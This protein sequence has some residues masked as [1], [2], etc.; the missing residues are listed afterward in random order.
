MMKKILTLAALTFSL[1][2]LAQGQ[3]SQLDMSKY[4][5]DLKTKS[6]MHI[7]SERA[8]SMSYRFRN[9]SALKVED[10]NSIE[11]K[12]M[13]AIGF[14]QRIDH[15]YSVNAEM[16]FGFSGDGDQEYFQGVV[17]G[18]YQ[19]PMSSDKWMAT[20]GLGVSFSQFQT[21]NLN[22][23]KNQ[24]AWLEGVARFGANYRI[25]KKLTLNSRV[26]FFQAGLGA[27]ESDQVEGNALSIQP[28]GITY[29]Y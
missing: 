5:S 25:N 27:I 13:L 10:Q 19:R 26:D 11:D 3:S 15:Q 17:M 22:T 21:E 20:F 7:D 18:T 6:D 4:N 23:N 24:V 14:E 9:M 8:V 1:Q 28:I 29:S 16:G 2:S 12:N